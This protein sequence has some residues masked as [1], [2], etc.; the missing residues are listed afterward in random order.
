VNSPDPPAS[1]PSPA[2]LPSLC[3]PPH[4]R[5]FYSPP[6][7][8]PPSAVPLGRGFFPD[9]TVDPHN[10]Q[11]L[12]PYNLRQLLDLLALATALADEAGGGAR[13]GELL[14]TF[15]LQV[16]APHAEI[17]LDVARYYEL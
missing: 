10:L 6:S 17:L 8:L 2:S 4:K 16:A 14:G 5:S 13:A 15:R 1:P 11:I 7:P 9:C 3:A 12:L